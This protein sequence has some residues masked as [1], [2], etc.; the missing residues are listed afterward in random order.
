ML[1]RI[2][3]LGSRLRQRLTVPS[4]IRAGST[5]ALLWAAWTLLALVPLV[6][7]T[8][9]ASVYNFL[10]L[11]LAAALG[12][13][14]AALVWLGLRLVARINPRLLWALLLLAVVFLP[15]T[16]LGAT[17]YAV[18]GLLALAVALVGGGLVAVRAQPGAWPGIAALAGGSIL[19]V[20]FLVGL[21]LDGWQ[22]EEEIVWEPMQGPGLELDDPA[23]P[24][25]FSVSEYTYGPGNDPH[26]DAFGAGVS[27][28]T[29]PVDGSKLL[30]GWEG[31]AG[32]ARTAYW[33]A[34]AETLPVRGRIWLPEGEGPFPLVLIVH[35]N[36]A[37]ED[38]SD[39]GY[40]YLGEL[41][42]SRGSIAASVDQNFLNLSTSSLLGLFEGG[43]EE[44]NDA[45]GWMLLEHVRQ[46]RDWGADPE[47]PLHGLVDV[48]RVVL[49]GHSRG[50]EAVSEAAVF[51]RL[52]HYP[53]DATLAFDYNFGIKGIIAVA[54]VDHQ[55]HPRDFDTVMRD[56][57]YL[58]IHGSHDSDVNS[59]AGYAAYSRLEYAACA[60]C[61][62]AG[63]YLIGA[64]HGQFNTSWG[65]YDVPAP[66]DRFL[67]IEPLMD[68]AAQRRVAEV[69]FS[70]F[71]E[72]TVHDK[73][74]Y[75]QLVAAPGRQQLLFGE[76][77]RFLSHYGAADDYVIADYDED[78]DVATATLA[79][80][81]IRGSDLTLWREADLS[82]KW[83]SADNAM[84][85]LGW[86]AP[87][88][89]Y[90]VSGITPHPGAR[91][92]SL[93]L[94]LSEK[95]PGEME[96]Y[97]APERIDF[98]VEIE[99]AAGNTARLP[100][101]ARRALLPQ[102]K[103]VMYKLPGLDADAPSEVV[104][105]RYR[106]ALDEF[107]AQNPQVS[108]ETLR[109]VSFVFDVTEAGSIWLDDLTLSSRAD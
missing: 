76:A 97:E 65:R 12:V 11:L 98:H 94:G 14:G 49:I 101:S 86:Q 21:L 60:D 59:Y 16:W 107:A 7:L 41:F 13:L 42:A 55:Y 32:W 109:R 77:A 103:P 73:L 10:A 6:I 35:G 81:A 5:R 3:N 85:Q 20:V 57:S 23:A 104:M 40:D 66:F 72:A 46:F 24:G 19:V 74:E 44:E 38:F 28:V 95:S 43:L 90:D 89:R 92:L 17:L 52:S 61:F 87:G 62:R 63:F 34:D 56:V 18:L 1:A 84:A 30:D 48:D 22:V 71:L 99:D 26:R 96:D 70:A 67:N 78:A 102:V 80:A 105:Q 27:F 53:D 79:G 33:D 83:R 91:V 82:L 15:F 64:N 108:V 39:G 37:M 9:A 88:A 106:F 75:R 68:G 50:G 36:H 4:D 51:N 2:R 45:R 25:P 47:H 29:E 100:I 58:V 93:A 8:T 54:P 31:A 69:L